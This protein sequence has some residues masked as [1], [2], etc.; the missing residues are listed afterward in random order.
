MWAGFVILGTAHGTLCMSRN[1]WISNT[2]RTH[3]LHS[4]T[5]A[6]IL[7]KDA[8]FFSSLGDRQL[9]TYHSETVG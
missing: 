6:F 3:Y 9:R 4:G 2:T 8:Q 7:T 5:V 1:H